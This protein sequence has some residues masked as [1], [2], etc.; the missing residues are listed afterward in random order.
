MPAL[1]R[2][3]SPACRAAVARCRGRACPFATHIRL[4]STVSASKSFLERARSR[5]R[6]LRGGRSGTGAAAG[7][8]DLGADSSPH[9]S[10]FQKSAFQFA[11]IS[12]ARQAFASALSGETGPSST[13]AAATRRSTSRIA[14]TSRWRRAG[15]SGR[16]ASGQNGPTARHRPRQLLEPRSRQIRPAPPAVLRVVAQFDKPFARRAWRRAG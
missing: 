4:S 12:L 9:R 7:S 6:G 15:S 3:V 2:L 5:P 1:A 10:R 13:A 8:Q 11:D 16:A 14:P